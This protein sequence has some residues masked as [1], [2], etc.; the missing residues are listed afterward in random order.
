MKSR[1]FN[2]HLKAIPRQSQKSICSISLLTFHQRL[3]WGCFWRPPFCACRCLTC[4]AEDTSW[5]KG[6]QDYH[7]RREAG[8]YKQS[9]GDHRGLYYIKLNIFFIP[10]LP[11]VCYITK[12]CI[13]M[14][15]PS[16]FPISV[17]P[18]LHL[19]TL[20]DNHH[21][22]LSLRAV[23]KGQLYSPSAISPSSIRSG[24]NS[25]KVYNSNTFID[26]LYAEPCNLLHIF[27]SRIMIMKH[28]IL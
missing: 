16:T 11:T 8:S 10:I 22:F 5:R 28:R 4:L 6:R 19:Q 25:N 7:C 23:S 26:F 9:D 24:K 21:Q 13:Y 12:S 17:H 15:H 20:V 2:I 14:K 27:S 1:N 18:I 3:D